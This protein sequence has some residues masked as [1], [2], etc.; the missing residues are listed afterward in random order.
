[1]RHLL[2]VCFAVVVAG[3]VARADGAAP[4][5][6][7]GR[8]KTF[9]YQLQNLE[10]PGAVEGLAK[11]DY[12]MLV[13]EPTGT[14]KE[15]AGFDVKGMVE[16]LHAGKQGRLVIAYLDAG[17]AESF[18]RYWRPEWKAP[19]KS[20]RGVPDFLIIPDP[21]G[22]SDDYPVA[23]WDGW[24]KEI[25]ASGA[26]SEVRTAMRAGFDGVYLDWIDA[27]DDDAVVAAA[28]LARVEPAKAMVDFLLLIRKTAREINPQAVVIQQNAIYLL[29][30]DPRL[31]E[32]IDGVGVEDTWFSGKANATWGSKGAGD[33]ANREKGEDSTSARLKQYRKFLAAGKPVFTIDYCR[34]AGHA[35]QVYRDA[36]ANGLVPL[37]TQ[38]SLDHLTDSPPPFPRP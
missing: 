8:M 38:V 30:R 29:D 32:A 22:W 9:M 12:D 3:V 25:F 6:P 11:S 17:Q 7:L 35:A 5:N 31:V 16:K 20:V 4:E 36:R 34:D 15:N 23:Y 2:F 1:M 13:V 10:A 33:V 24:W 14:T 37:V 21:D 26:E 19:T 27:F 18:R 28:K